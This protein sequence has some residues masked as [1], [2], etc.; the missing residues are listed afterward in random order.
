MRRFW[1]DVMKFLIVLLAT[2][3][4]SVSVIGGIGHSTGGFVTPTDSSITFTNAYH[5]C[6]K[7]LREKVGTGIYVLTLG[8]AKHADAPVW[9]FSFYNP[10]SNS[11]I[12]VKWED[13][14]YDENGLARLRDISRT[15]AYMEPDYTFDEVM[16]LMERKG[17][18]PSKIVH[19]RF[20]GLWQGDSRSQLHVGMRDCVELEIDCKAEVVAE[21]E[22][23]KQS[24]WKWNHL[25]ES[26]LE[27]D[28]IS[29][30]ETDEEKSLRSIVLDLFYLSFARMFIEWDPPRPELECCF[31]RK[32]RE[33]GLLEKKIVFS[34]YNCT[35]WE[36]FEALSKKVPIKFKVEKSSL[37]VTLADGDDGNPDEMERIRPWSVDRETQK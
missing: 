2:A 12:W 8:D 24:N 31:S 1:S 15:E 11:C 35:K 14:L 3:V 23:S 33:S 32:L 37:I 27:Q 36:A 25:K 9:T 16:L 30:Y 26:V 7:A 17:F 29:Y 13:G 20:V 21:T 4:L 5:Q 22:F 34:V 19:A 28:R 10:A 18:D 6:R